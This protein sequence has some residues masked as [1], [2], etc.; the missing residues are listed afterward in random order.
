MPFY[1]FRVM[2]KI[3]GTE[4]MVLGFGRWSVQIYK[5]LEKL[6]PYTRRIDDY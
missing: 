4:R 5:G 1:V 6:G 2:S 3:W